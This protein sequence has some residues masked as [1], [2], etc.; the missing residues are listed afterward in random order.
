MSLETLQQF[1]WSAMTPEFIILGVSALLTLLDL[2]M[3]K[4]MDRKILGWIGIAAIFA[5][6]VSV[7]GMV[8]GPVT[9]ILENS[10]RLD[11][12]AMAFKLLLLAGAGLVMF[13]AV[14]YE[15]KDGLEE[16]RGEFYYLFLSALLG[17]MIMTSSG[18]LI[19][20]FIGLELL[21]V[22][23]YI[24]AGIRKYH[25]ESNESAMKYV[26]NGGIST[27]IT[28]FGM[29]Y[30]YGLTGSTNLLDIAG[31]LSTVTGGQQAYLLTLAFLMV[32]VGLA[33]KLGAAPFHMWAP[34]VY[35]GA[36]T[37]VTAFLSVVSKTAGF[38][39]VL[40]ILLTV[41][42]SAASVGNPQ[43][44]ILLEMQDYIAFI[45]GATM[46]IGNF[47]ALKQSNIK[48]MFAYSS[49]AHAGY[50]LVA[51]T[52]LS[53][54]MFYSIWFYLLAYL[55]MNL[56]AF[57][58]IQVV[59]EKTGSTEI[60]DFAG[61][62][63]RSPVLAVVMGLLL[64][65]L[66]GFPGT[67]GFIGKLNIFI[68]AFY[69][70]PHYVLASIMIATTVVSYFYYFGVMTQMFFRPA[71]DDSKF[72]LPFG[73]IVVLIVAVVGSVL[74]GVMPNIALDFMQNNLDIL[75]DFFS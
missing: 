57:A 56:G 32:F 35:Q 50:I 26:I 29:S 15:P 72:N 41:F 45:A 65:S 25:L 1:N 48:R 68:G 2:F 40:R 9:S 21:T 63:R 19:T 59:S 64:V 14:S 71:S 31:R 11:S 33:F 10:F 42:G 51:L 12:F 52:S 69:G 8:G 44:P 3:P 75:A 18:D 61:L 37:P 30:I 6:I 67:A 62:Y 27:A 49:I 70:T 17:A 22:S 47:I 36:P 23:S 7:L 39:I 58:V 46:I 13:L 38:V 20:L 5:A 73:I 43:M 53:S 16:Y 55:F 4:N 24:L 74:F 60:A 54:N 34:D 66:A 28:L